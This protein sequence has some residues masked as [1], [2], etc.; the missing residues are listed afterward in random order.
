MS[1][2]GRLSM[3]ARLATLMMAIGILALAMQASGAQ[4][5]GGACQYDDFPGQ[6]TIEAVVPQAEPWPGLPYAALSVTFRFVPDGPVADPLYEPG[7]LHHLT[8]AG[9]RPPGERFMKAHALRQGRTIPCRLRL[10]RQGTCTPVLFEFPGIDL[11]SDVDF[12]Q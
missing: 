12:A 2:F 8:L 7:A 11:A 6:A 9:G 1:D 4:A 10:I 3:R 5:V